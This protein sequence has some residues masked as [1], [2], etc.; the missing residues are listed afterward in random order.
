[1]TGIIGDYTETARFPT[2]T[3][4]LVPHP[5]CPR[6]WGSIVGDERD[7]YCLACGCRFCPLCLGAKIAD[8]CSRCSTGSLPLRWNAGH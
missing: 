1:M 2:D 3:D 7:L 6:C 4:G 5:R 8:L